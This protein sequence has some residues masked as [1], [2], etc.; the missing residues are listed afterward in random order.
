M[1]DQYF[2]IYS[3]FA[4][5]LLYLLSPI[6]PN[7]LTGVAVLLTCISGVILLV[8]GGTI[9]IP[10][11]L[12]LSILA[13]TGVSLIINP[14]FAF[15]GWMAFLVRNMFYVSQENLVSTLTVGFLCLV[16]YIVRRKHFFG[17]GKR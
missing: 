12:D 2:I 6:L 14:K 13:F 17:F 1:P 11:L 15:W 8:T 5:Y 4:Q 9:N 10:G 3:V 16:W 7:K